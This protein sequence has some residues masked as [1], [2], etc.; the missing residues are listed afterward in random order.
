MDDGGNPASAPPAH[1]GAHAPDPQRRGEAGGP[2]PSPAR[3]SAQ[4]PGLRNR[5]GPGRRGN[6][7]G[8]RHRPGRRRHGLRDGLGIRERIGYRSR[9]RP[10]DGRLRVGDRRLRLVCAYVSH[11]MSHL[12]QILPGTPGGIRGS[13]ARAEPTGAASARVARGWHWRRRRR[14]DPPARLG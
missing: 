14:A 12:P 11:H 3:R 4:R 10:G 1:T 5:R 9:V 6:R 7:I 13:V 8:L 2:R